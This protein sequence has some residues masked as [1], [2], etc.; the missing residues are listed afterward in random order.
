MPR[1]SQRSFAYGAILVALWQSLGH[2][3]TF[4]T[5][6]EG[7]VCSSRNHLAVP[8]ALIMWGGKGSLQRYRRVGLCW[9]GRHGGGLFW[10]RRWRNLAGKRGS[11]PIRI[12][13]KPTC[14]GG[15]DGG[16]DDY[17]GGVC[18]RF[19]C[20]FYVA[21]E[22][23]CRGGGLCWCFWSSFDVAFQRGCCH[24]WRTYQGNNNFKNKIFEFFK[25]IQ[26]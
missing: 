11:P 17:G 15:D 22:R 20:L 12:F 25:S 19:W 1:G 26:F 5:A 13:Q 3:G 24:Y 7:G 4:S 14:G 10:N 2:R 9:R 18:Q 21:H 8:C 23:G 16:G 6:N